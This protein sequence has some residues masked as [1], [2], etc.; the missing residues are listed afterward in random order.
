MDD[1]DAEGGERASTAEGQSS[2]TGG[3]GRRGREEVDETER[4]NGRKLKLSYKVADGMA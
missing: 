1:L 4:K 3:E 2:T